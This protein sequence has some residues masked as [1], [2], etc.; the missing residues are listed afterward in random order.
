MNNIF[1]NPSSRKDAE[2]LHQWFKLMLSKIDIDETMDD[3]AKNNQRQNVYLGAFQELQKQV[4]VQCK[5]RGDLLNELW[6]GYF[7]DLQM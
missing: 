1:G 6:Q 2:T 4:A 5:N 3:A 7:K